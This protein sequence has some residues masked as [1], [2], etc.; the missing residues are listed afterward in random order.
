MSDYFSF[1]LQLSY[2]G[3]G[4]YQDMGPQDGEYCFACWDI[5]QD[6]LSSADFFQKQLFWKI[7]PGIP[8][9]CQTVSNQ[10]RPDMSSGLTWVQSVYKGYQQTTECN[11]FEILAFQFPY[12]LVLTFTKL[13]VN[14][15]FSLTLL[16]NCPDFFLS[17]CSKLYSYIMHGSNVMK[18]IK[19]IALFML[20]SDATK[21]TI[22]CWSEEAK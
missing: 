20:L 17:K 14:A 9:E 7:L 16:K 4:N 11:L 3:P 2:D 10:F 18:T 22:I 5:F 21:S 15:I 12:V 13:Y 19:N 6:F 1:F 8:L